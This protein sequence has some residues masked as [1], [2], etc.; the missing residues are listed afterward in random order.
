MVDGKESRGDRRLR[1]GSLRARTTKKIESL[2][3]S[4]EG[5]GIEQTCTAARRSS[6]LSAPITQPKWKETRER[7]ASV[8]T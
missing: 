5:D 7:L 6:H 2:V 8:W 1:G 4:D 3:V